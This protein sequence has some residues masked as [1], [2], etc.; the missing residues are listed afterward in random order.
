MVIA[1][2]SAERAMFSHVKQNKMIR[3][4]QERRSFPC[5]KNDT[6]SQNSKATAVCEF[7]SKFPAFYNAC[8]SLALRVSSPET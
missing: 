7:R 5:E 2:Q 1:S 6:F 8:S 3:P 4:N